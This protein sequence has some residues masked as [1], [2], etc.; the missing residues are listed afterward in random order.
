MNT[1]NTSAYDE[2]LG[3][4]QSTYDEAVAKLEELEASLLKG[5]LSAEQQSLATEY[6][7]TMVQCDGSA[8]QHYAHAL[9]YGN[10]TFEERYG[11]THQ[12]IE[13]ALQDYKLQLAEAVDDDDGGDVTEAGT[14]YFTD[15]GQADDLPD[16]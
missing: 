13:F 4:L 7:L 9:R 14:G 8:R 11:G 1:M 12:Q 15:A 2:E 5:T 10:L 3:R 16:K 6:W